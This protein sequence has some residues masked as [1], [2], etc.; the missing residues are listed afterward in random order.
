MNGN[1]CNKIETDVMLF[2]KIIKQ[3][4]QERTTSK[5]N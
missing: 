2:I 4:L 5:N 3:L 1:S